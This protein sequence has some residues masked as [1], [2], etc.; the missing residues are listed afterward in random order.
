MK[1]T[2]EDCE[3]TQLLAALALALVDRPR[4]SLQELAK[5]VGVGKS[6]LHR[7]SPTREE[8]LERLY[9][10]NM[11]MVTQ[12]ISNACLENCSPLAGLRALTEGSLQHPEVT[13][14]ITYYWKYAGVPQAN[15]TCLDL[16]YKHQMVLDTFFLRGQ[17]AG[18]FRI[19]I[20]AATLTEL[21]F[22]TVAG[23][24]DAQ[25]RGR[26]ARVGLGELIES[27]FLQ[28]AGYKS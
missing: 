9:R 13:A 24:L 5:A 2:K 20:T 16:S 14:F 21:W 28:G 1:P 22:I 10:H 11:L 27:T 15:P 23:L 26:I 17:K 8:L 4:A 25:R 3:N 7:F 6:T 19:D 12:L 18:A